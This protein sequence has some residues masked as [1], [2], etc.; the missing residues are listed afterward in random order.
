MNPATIP[1]ALLWL[2]IGLL[3]AV[4]L[5]DRCNSKDILLGQHRTLEANTITNQYVNKLGQQVTVASSNY[6]TK[7]ELK[8]SRDVT[9]DSLRKT[10]VGPLK[11]IE[12]VTQITYQ[13]LEH[14][15]I[16]V[17]DTTVYVNNIATPASAFKYHTDFMDLKGYL[18]GDSLHLDYALKGGWN[19]QYRWKP[20]SVFKPKELELTVTAT[21]PA[22]T[23][24]RI[25]QFQVVA[26]VP[27]WRKPGVAFVA[28][29]LTLG[30][31][32]L[33]VK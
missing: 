18:A 22:V 9:I 31:I 24:N 1:K 33:Y 28:G 8:H 21:D 10:L 16:A 32:E 4:L 7:E 11:N 5:N 19:L 2:I 27:F 6:I 13:R 30:A 3:V 12:R 20:V 26:P 29:A 15:N 17:T 23:V 14:L 25:Q